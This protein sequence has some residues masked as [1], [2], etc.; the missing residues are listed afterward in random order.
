[1]LVQEGLLPPGHGDEEEGD[2]EGG[3][4]RVVNTRVIL[5]GVLCF[6]GTLVF[7]IVEPNLAL[8]L[9]ID[10]GLSQTAIGGIFAG[11]ELLLLLLLLRGGTAPDLNHYP[12]TPSQWLD[13]PNDDDD[14]DD[15]D[16]DDGGGSGGDGDAE[17]DDGVDG[18]DDDDHDDDEDDDGDDD[19]DDDDDNDDDDDDDDD[20]GG[21]FNNY[22]MLLLWDFCVQSL[23]ART[24]SSASPLVGS[25]TTTGTS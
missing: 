13:R 23:R 19:D 9:K 11:T 7:G 2:P 16:G 10:T 20:D 5:S 24:P 17:D 8:H 22:L 18:G 14:D 4:M 1:M 21:V 15:D 6:C 12:P 25:Q 3:F